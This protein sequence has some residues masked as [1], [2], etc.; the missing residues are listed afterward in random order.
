MTNEERICKLCEYVM[1]LINKILSYNEDYYFNMA[2]EDVKYKIR[3]IKE[4]IDNN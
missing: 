4:D 2:L 1:D 3:T